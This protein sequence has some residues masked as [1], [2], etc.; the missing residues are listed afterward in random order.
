MY[1]LVLLKLKNNY[2]KNQERA[3]HPSFNSDI[4]KVGYIKQGNTMKISKIRLINFKRFT[5]YTIE[6][7]EQIN[8]L[9]GDNEAGKS[10]ILEAIDL[11]SSGSIKKVEAI[12]L[13]R[14][15]NLE[16]VKI[17]NAGERIFTKL[18]KLRIELYFDESSNFKT[19]GKCNLDEKSCDGIKLVCEPNLDFNEDITN[20]LTNS[21]DIFPYDF[22]SIRFSTFADEGYNGYHK[23]IHT[24]LIDSSNMNGE[25]MTN[26]FIRNM[27]SQYTEHDKK[28]RINHKSSYRQMRMNFQKD[29]L[30]SLNSLISAK[31]NYYFGLK[32]G[33]AI[34]LESDLMIYENEIGVDCRGMGKQTLIKTEFA[35]DRAGKSCDAILIEEPE[36]H[37]SPTNLRKLIQEITKNEQGQLFITTHNSLISSRL[38]LSNLL[39]MHSNRDTCPVMLKNLN[40]ET[41]KYF[42][43][44]PAAGIIEFALAN[45]VILVEGPSEYMLMERFYQTI[46]GH[47]PEITGIHIINVRGLS[48]KR[49]LDI[50]KLTNSKVAVIT[51]NDKNPQ[52]NCIEKYQEYS[53]AP[54]IEIFFD[55]DSNK[56]T[57]EV[58]LYQDN[59]YLCDQLF[60]SSAQE[61]MLNNKTE[62]AY[63]LLLEKGTIQVP[64]YIQRAIKWINE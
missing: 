62:A 23:H 20:L 17:F 1:K 44:A 9:V 7:N 5:D 63:K 36:N 57:F 22:Y 4:I 48:F 14:L 39:I 12:G 10:S 29:S 35:L 31:K 26:A 30:H 46:V 43:K 28:E 18:P 40:Q 25:Y 59:P 49:Y 52:K 56:Y 34:A 13:D 53:D 8:I 41:G 6:P 16:A 42:I 37:L 24:T 60:G 38:E 45:K 61:Y 11:V 50:C 64:E 32:K 21:S 55:S 27:Y 15:L 33:S 54:N 2:A 47:E 3:E 58:A 19:N 51:D